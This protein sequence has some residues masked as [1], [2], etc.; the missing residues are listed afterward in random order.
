MSVEDAPINGA[1]DRTEH[2]M[3]S[4][5][6]SPHAAARHKKSPAMGFVVGEI[7]GRAPMRGTPLVPSNSGRPVP[8]ALKGSNLLT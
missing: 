7:M 3:G 6:T 1:M 2:K 4:S 5:R 8:T